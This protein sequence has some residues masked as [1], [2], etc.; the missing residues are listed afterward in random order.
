M[1][2]NIRS[3]HKKF[4]QIT[5]TISA[6]NCDIFSATESWLKKEHPSYAF[7]IPDFTFFRCD[8][9]HK[10]GGGVCAWLRNNLFANQIICETSSKEI[11]NIYDHELLILELPNCNILYGIIYI[12]PGFNMNDQQTLNLHL[13]NIFD[14]LL[15]KYTHHSIILCGD[16]NFFN[17]STLTSNLNLK[18]CTSSA[19]R[20]NN[21]LDIFLISEFIF[22][23]FHQCKVGPPICNS[24]H[25]TILLEPK[26]LLQHPIAPKFCLNLNHSS[27]KAFFSCLNNANW[28][29]E[30]PCH[31]S[32]DV[33][34]T[35]NLFNDIIQTAKTVIPQ[36]NITL[37]SKDKPWVSYKLKHMF[38]SKWDAWRSNNMSK[39]NYLK[40]KIRNEIISCKQKWANNIKNQSSNM[41]SAI[42]KIRGKDSNPISK[43]LAD[44]NYNL[45]N[46]INAITQQFSNIYG[47]ISMNESFSNYENEDTCSDIVPISEEYVN[48]L[49]NK[50][51]NKKAAGSDGIPTVLYKH[52]A[53]I[54][55]KPLSKI[56]NLC[57]AHSIFPNIW[58][59]A[60]IIP[61]AKTSPIDITNLRP[62]SLLPL[63]G[64][65]FEKVI[66]CQIKDTL[67]SHYDNQQFGFRPGSSTTCALLALQSHIVNFL[68]I[69]EVTNV[70]MI[71]FDLS[72]AFDR[73]CHSILLKKLN[74]LSN[75]THAL[76]KDFL[77]NR[78]NKVIINGTTGPSFHATS[79]VPQGSVL[80]PY[81]FNIFFADFLPYSSKSKI[82]KYADDSHVLIPIPKNAS[83]KSVLSSIQ[84]E[85]DSALTWCTKNN[86]ILNVNKIK[87]MNIFFS[88]YG[89]TPLESD[90]HSFLFAENIKIL[91]LI[92]NHKLNWKN[93]CTYITKIAS[94]RLYALRILK[95]LMGKNEL[96]AMYNGLVRNILEYGSPVFVASTKSY[97]MKLDQIQ[98]RAHRIICGKQSCQCM[99]D[100]TERKDRAS[101]KLF[102]KIISCKSHILTPL[103]PALSTRTGNFIMPTCNTT[104]KLNLFFTHLIR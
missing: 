25:N 88:P 62:L 90:K 59:E 47:P 36:F 17:T 104:R 49:I 44:H 71:T 92:M 48:A 31:N 84:E 33:N 94:Q 16:F 56:F 51:A 60:L 73:V 18:T 58:K 87:I 97:Q 20:N 102:N 72:K 34:L 89:W 21:I 64:K 80:A 70:I 57:I 24:D 77:L 8:R 7:P 78:Q 6:S 12:P 82:V 81:L 38:N 37:S 9:D 14:N 28:C 95:N 61:I 26:Q 98:R 13:I 50:T 41:W 67:I 32:K 53:V 100:L 23:K 85:I 75:K 99:E 79:G 35:V 4:D 2:A 29:S 15:L 45:H 91:G 76:I 68:D 86:Q 66:L 74:F 27:L 93:H 5:A 22:T 42:N 65:I 55:S 101:L 83:H 1:L 10:R 103:M 52:V 43:L 19:T 3:L 40:T 46:L 63:P 11:N 69:K 96:L 39:F 54:I 30:H